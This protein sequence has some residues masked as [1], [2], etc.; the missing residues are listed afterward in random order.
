MKIIKSKKTGLEHTITDDEYA[1]MV[2]EGVIIKRFDVIETGK[3]IIPSF[4]TVPIE[5]KKI[6]KKTEK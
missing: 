5:I 3:T 1:A 2:R 4:K 6:I